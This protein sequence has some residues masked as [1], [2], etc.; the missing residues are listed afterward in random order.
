MW[1]RNFITWLKRVTGI[2]YAEFPPLSDHSSK[3]E[4]LKHKANQV[5]KDVELLERELRGVLG[6]GRHH[7]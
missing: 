5:Q 4:A 3:T 7:R 6:G 1:W 2:G